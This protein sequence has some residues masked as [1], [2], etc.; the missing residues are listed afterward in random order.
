MRVRLIAS[1]LPLA[2]A[3]L[4]TPPARAA[5]P[6]AVAIL[7]L[8]PRGIDAEQVQAF[9]RNLREAFM[10]DARVRMLEE[11]AMYETL[12]G[13]DGNA[14]LRQAR[15]L[16]ADGKKDYRAKQYDTARQKLEA[17]RAL[18]RAL[19]SELSRTGELADLL[20]YEGLVLAQQQKKD[21]AQ[22]TFLQMFLLN[23]SID[24]TRGPPIDVELMRIIE[25][26]R[27]QERELPLR[28]VN[29][30]FAA[31]IATK[32]E[33]GH[34]VTGVVEAQEGSS[35]ATVRLQ[36]VM[37]GRRQPETTMIFE[38]E[39]VSSGMPPAGSPVYQR[40]VGVSGRVLAGGAP[41][42]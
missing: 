16:L 41:R 38:V 12:D 13:S 26:A 3:L 9:S 35:R 17:A 37:P 36:F 25:A 2:L 10:L 34:L 27:R 11:R 32:L 28:G 14:R 5:D 23:P 19:Y 40:I 33:V 24:V 22:V 7:N 18:H 4:S 6:P 20:L 39:D 42:E 31:D 29:A 1:I 8:T 15:A 21:L 30:A